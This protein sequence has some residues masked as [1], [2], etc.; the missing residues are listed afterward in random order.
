MS[1]TSSETLFGINNQ[2]FLEKKTTS[3]PDLGLEEQGHTI[4]VAISLLILIAFL[5]SIGNLLVLR[6]IFSQKKRKLHEYLILN[7]AATDAGTCLLGIPFDVAEQL[8]GSFPYGAALC[9]VIYP[10][11]SLLIY[12]SVMTL[13]FM[14]VERYRL[15]VTPMKPRIRLRTGLKII[16]GM[17]LLMCLI[18]LPL[19]LVLKFKGSYCSEEWP[20]AYSAKVFTLIVFAFLY[21]IP[22][23]VMT[24]LY[25][26]MIKVLNKD[27][28]S[29]KRRSRTISQESLNLQ[30]TRNV[31][32]VKVFIVAVV[33]F[34]V[35]MLPTHIT[36]LWHDFGD[37]SSRP[38]LFGKIVAFSNIL[39]YAN[40]VFNPLIFGYIM[41]K[42]C[43]TLVCCLSRR[44]KKDFGKVFVLQVRSPS[45]ETQLEKGSFYLS[46][47][48]SSEIFNCGDNGVVRATKIT[49]KKN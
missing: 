4:S 8:I 49:L 7:L 14:C 30:M 5:G 33:V 20:H 18:V 2:T 9:R 17:W 45:M 37:G 24:V 31:T 47:S 35:C 27:T 40:S 11:Q 13:L 29:L 36:W 25:S 26:L 16:A 41:V 42:P 1:Q 48:R 23:L 19:S 43:R 44:N 38:E 21:V 3:G 28:E 39:M 15:I 12:S 34:T 22:L 32:V 6:A 46:L 10:F